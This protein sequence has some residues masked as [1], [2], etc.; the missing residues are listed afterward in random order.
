MDSSDIFK[1][2]Y[3]EKYKVLFKHLVDKMFMIPL[4]IYRTDRVSFA[5]MGEDESKGGRRKAIK[6]VKDDE[7][8][9]IKYVITNPHKELKIKE[10]DVVFVLAQSDPRTTS[11]D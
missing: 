4:G 9:E 7:K 8:K 6:T 11:W 1:P 2:F 5:A 3:G 10:S